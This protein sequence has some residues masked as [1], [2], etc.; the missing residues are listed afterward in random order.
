MAHELIGAFWQISRYIKE[1]V[2][3]HIDFLIFTVFMVRQN[4]QIVED[5]MD[6]RAVECKL[7]QFQTFVRVGGSLL[8][9]AKQ[10]LEW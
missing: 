2:Y 9:Q 3:I 4:P 10:G 7:S 5:E 8:D 1:K 6:D